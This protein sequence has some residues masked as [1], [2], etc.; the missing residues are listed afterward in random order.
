MKVLVTGAGGFVG[1]HLVAELISRRHDVFATGFPTS[2][3]PE[4]MLIPLDIADRRQTGEVLCQVRP[5]AVVHLAAQSKIALAWEEPAA[6]VETNTVGTINLIAALK[7]HSPHAKIIIAG[8]SEEYGLT[9]QTGQLLTE[10]SPCRPHNPYAVSKLAAG[11]IGAQLARRAGLSLYHLRPFN[12]F[13]PGQPPGFII[14]DFCS[15]LARIERGLQAPRLEVGDLSAQRD[16]TYI[17]DI[18]AAY[19]AVL[20]SGPE[21]GIYNV[22]SG[23]TRS[24]QEILEF[25][26]RQASV[27]VEVRVDPGRFRPAEVPV[28]RGSAEK[29]R[30]STG[31]RAGSAFYPSLL[32][33]LEWWRRNT[34]S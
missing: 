34:G 22:C 2:N 8:S 19:A 31:W 33:T 3:L 6:A 11:Q 17:A 18:V 30:Q 12:H 10:N 32:K 20:E 1:S 16:F 7:E 23:L 15:Q 28:F 9:G 26:T 13:G 21:P 29:L 5:D 14:S 27:P 24:G 25:L 4:T